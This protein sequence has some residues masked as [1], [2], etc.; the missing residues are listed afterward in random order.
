MPWNPARAVLI[1]MTRLHYL[2]HVG[3]YTEIKTMVPHL[4]SNVLYMT[5]VLTAMKTLSVMMKMVEH[6][7]K[8]RGDQ[9]CQILRGNR[10]LQQPLC[11]DAMKPGLHA[12]HLGL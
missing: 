11:R 5:N 8:D 3:Q 6:E 10:F 9:V 4:Q 2:L 12:L 7:H 1:N